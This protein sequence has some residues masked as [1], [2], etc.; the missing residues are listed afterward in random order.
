MPDFVLILTLN[1]TS[2]KD[3]ASKN[4]HMVQ[5]FWAHLRWKKMQQDVT[6]F[7]MVARDINVNNLCLHFRARTDLGCIFYLWL[8]KV[9]ANEKNE[10]QNDDQVQDCGNC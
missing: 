9:S 4:D 5:E 8:S 6:R 10:I 1:R 7:L 2:N 3:N